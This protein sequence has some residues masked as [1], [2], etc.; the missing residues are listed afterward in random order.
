MKTPRGGDILTSAMRV[1]GKVISFDFRVLFWWE[2]QDAKRNALVLDD[3]SKRRTFN[4]AKFERLVID[5]SLERVEDRTRDDLDGKSWID[6]LP[7]RLIPKIYSI[8]EGHTGIP[9][10]ELLRFREDVKAY[11]DPER[12]NSTGYVAPSELLEIIMLERLGGITRDELRRLGYSEYLKIHTIVN[13]MRGTGGP[14]MPRSPEGTPNAMGGVDL[15]SMID[16]ARPISHDELRAIDER[17]NEVGASTKAGEDGPRDR[18]KPRG[19]R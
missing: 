7:F 10:E 13:L 18:V 11:Y 8:Y 4:Q 15:S 3:S 6:V 5:T 9:R 14:P 2:E 17:R 1:K 19:E 12:R 16:P